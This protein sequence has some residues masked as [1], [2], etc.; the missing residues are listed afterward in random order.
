M[1]NALA[2]L[3]TDEHHIQ[4]QWHV[5][6]Y[7]KK[8]YRQNLSEQVSVEKS[9]FYHYLFCKKQ[10]FALPILCLPAN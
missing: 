3:A 8:S 9:W 7:Y 2:F 1:L 6:V 4:V 5:T 10:R